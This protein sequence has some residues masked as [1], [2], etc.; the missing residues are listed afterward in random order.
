[1]WRCHTDRS[2]QSVPGGRAIHNYFRDYDPAIGRYIESDPIELAGGI[3]TYS[4]ALNDPISKSD[5]SGHMVVSPGDIA[6]MVETVVD[7]V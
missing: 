2:A 7:A 5:E 1:L 4:Y 3:N 6:N